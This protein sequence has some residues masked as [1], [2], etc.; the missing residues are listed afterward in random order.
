MAEMLR[1][2]NG[3]WLYRDDVLELFSEA[4]VP[5]SLVEDF[6]H[7]YDAIAVFLDTKEKLFELEEQ[8]RTQAEVVQKQKIYQERKA[9]LEA[10]QPYRV[11]GFFIIEGHSCAF[12]SYEPSTTPNFTWEIVVKSATKTFRVQKPQD[13][14]Y[15]ENEA[16]LKTYL[17]AVEAGTQHTK[18]S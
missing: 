6:M 17:A 16:A 4:G 1:D 3:A 12:V 11:G 13:F 15:F 5:N 18:R 7:S 10:E 9:T 8:E 2:H 14:L